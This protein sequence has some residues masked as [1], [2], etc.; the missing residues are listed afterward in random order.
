M[1][2]LFLATLFTFMTLA[3]VWS[4]GPLSWKFKIEDKGGGEVE[5]IGEVSIASGWSIYDISIPE[6][7]PNPT[8]IEIDKISGATKIG[9][10]KSVNSK[11][12]TKFDEMFGMTLSTYSGKAAFAQRLKITDKAKFAVEGAIR[13]QACNDEQCTP[14]NRYEFSFSGKDLPAT[15]STTSSGK[16]DQKSAISIEASDKIETAPDTAYPTAQVATIDTVSTTTSGESDLWTPV[17][18]ELEVFGAE[19]S[20]A[21]KTYAEIF[22]FGFLGGLIALLTPCVWPIIPMT[23]S[24]F[25]KR[26]KKSKGKAISEA[27]MYG[28]AI[29]AIYLTLGLLVTALF[30]AGALNK[31]ATDATFNI[32]F[33]LLLVVFAASFFGAF[34]MVLP[35]SWTNKMDSKA[36]STSGIIS[37]FFMAFTLVL[38]SFSCTGPI[39]GTLIVQAAASGEAI[40]PAVGMFGF[41][42]ALAIPFALFAIF[43][44]WLN[45]VPKSGGWLNSVK[46]VLGFLELALALK[47]LSVADLTKHWGI[48]DREVFLV[49]WII[50]FTLLG[51]YLLGKIKF[52]HDSDT[53]YVS[54]TRLFLAIVSLSFAVYMVP[55][56]WGAPLKAISAFAPPPSTQD[57]NLYTGS[58]HAK[59]TDYEEGME[60]A[61]RHNKPVLIDFSGWGCVNCREMETYV[62][63]DPRVK[64]ILENDYV[65][66]T[67]MVD[68]RELLPEVIEVEKNGKKMK[69]KTVGD[70]W[71]Y[72]QEHK[73]GFASQPYY[74]TLNSEGKPIGPSFAYDRNIDNYLTFLKTGLQNFEKAKNGK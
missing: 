11:A 38:V 32:I 33:F 27:L 50:I 10:F 47:F 44:S 13:S 49:L 29:I 45:N 3:N 36:D 26:N 63:I 46:V 74:V 20:I 18:K 55:G 21:N 62:W 17:I 71:A 66:I 40:A 25:L 52:K 56:L 70:K 48:L 1:K 43:P 37:I 22:I 42:L 57:F 72:L 65:L 19:G 8:S 73:F 58:V 12:K 67:L 4:A 5:L 15:L 6:G 53:K 59:F 69:L 28:F 39:I 16:E 24:F 9:N 35:A 23:V 2:K 34:E 61:R 64:N 51:L 54:V 60:Y 7:G 68:D 41:A 30:G 14:P 31:M